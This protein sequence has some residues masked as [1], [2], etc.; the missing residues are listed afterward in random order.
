MENELN[1]KFM[2]GGLRGAGCTSHG[3]LS[4]ATAQNYMQGK[5]VVFISILYAGAD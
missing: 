5:M 4:T 1:A 3:S 2:I